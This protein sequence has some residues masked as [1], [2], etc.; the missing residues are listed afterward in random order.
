MPVA[1][2][3]CRLTSDRKGATLAEVLVGGFVLSLLLLAVTEIYRNA[4]AAWIKGEQQSA[5]LQQVQLGLTRIDKEVERSVYDSLSIS[6]DFRGAALLSALYSDG[7]FMFDAP[8]QQP[9]WQ[10]YIVFYHDPPTRELRRVEVPV[11]GTP[12]ET[13]AAPIENFGAMTPIENYFVG[14]EVIARDI[15]QCVFGVTPDGLLSVLLKATKKGKS[16]VDEVE[17]TTQSGFRN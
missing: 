11:V 13:A 10:N 15:E 2:S 5:L 4:T 17:M 7:V 9:R 3:R 1:K 8:T 16:T 6:S 14:G 12:Q